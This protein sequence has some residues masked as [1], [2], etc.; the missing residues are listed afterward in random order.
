MDFLE[1]AN[2]DQRTW[3]WSQG[4]IGPDRILLQAARVEMEWEFVKYWWQTFLWDSWRTSR[5]RTSFNATASLDLTVMWKY[6]T[7]DGNKWDS[8]KIVRGKSSQPIFLVLIPQGFDLSRKYAFVSRARLVV[9]IGE[10][11]KSWALPQ[12]LSSVCALPSLQKKISLECSL[13]LKTKLENVQ[14]K[15][16][17]TL[18]REVG[19]NLR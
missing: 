4:T 15:T 14:R 16:T 2:E 6:L 13:Y 10:L 19:H 12:L 8:P 3:Q 5:R 7:R 18:V 11:H 9:R 1:I 17:L